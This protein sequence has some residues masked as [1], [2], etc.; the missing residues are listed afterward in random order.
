MNYNH[1]AVATTAEIRNGNH[2]QSLV[3]M[4]NGLKT[5]AEFIFMLGVYQLRF[6]SI[7][8]IYLN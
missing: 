2:G 7:E 1:N 4:Q 6:F 5:I 3:Q 8:N